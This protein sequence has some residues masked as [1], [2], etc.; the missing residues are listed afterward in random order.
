M[1]RIKH[2]YL[3]VNILYPERPKSDH[4]SGERENIP[5]VPGSMQ[6]HWPTPDCLTPQLL[7]KAIRDQIL[8]MYG[9]YGSGLSVTGLNGQFHYIIA[10]LP[11]CA[12]CDFIRIMRSSII[13]C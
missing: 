10:I 9:D 8:Y 13:G 11:V 3:L 4:Q 5:S 6:F 12:F 2:R 7:A 1:V